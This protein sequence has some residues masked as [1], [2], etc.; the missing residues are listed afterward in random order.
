M[1]GGQLVAGWEKVP[2]QVRF[3]LCHPTLLK[4]ILPADSDGVAKVDGIHETRT[5]S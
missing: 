3:D 4:N 1:E 5:C 2:E